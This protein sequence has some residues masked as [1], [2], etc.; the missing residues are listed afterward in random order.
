MTQL[1]GNTE[2][3][4][5]G[6]NATALARCVADRSMG[7]LSVA[8]VDV[9]SLYRLRYPETWTCIVYLLKFLCILY[10]YGSL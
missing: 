10:F 2:K 4:A 9:Q 1:G 5:G 7:I 3:Q 6:R 8:S